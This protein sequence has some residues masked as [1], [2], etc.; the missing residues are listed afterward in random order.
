M[1]Q[2]VLID[3]PLTPD[4]ILL[5][6]RGAQL[7]LSDQA[8]E[9]IKT[10]R[11]IV[12][13][14]VESGARGYGI[15]T[16]VGALCDIVISEENQ[17]ALSHN[18]L[19][20]HACG[21]GEPLEVEA[22]RA[23]MATQINNYAL[24]KSG[25]SWDCV[26]V[27]LLLLN[28]GITPVV[29][30]RGSVGYLTQTASI[31]LILL[32]AGQARQNGEVISGA[33]ALA[34][35]ERQP[36]VL[37]AKEGLSLV[38]GTPCATGLAILAHARIRELAD[39][40]DAA[41]ALSYS[42]LA[43]QSE[44]FTGSTIML[45]RSA[46]VQVTTENLLGW[47]EGVARAPEAKR[48]TQDPLSL[49]AIPQVHGAIRDELHQIHDVLATELCGV[50]DN[51]TVGG[52]PSEPKVFSQANAVGAAVAFAADR[53]SIVAA[54]L[55]AISERRVD[56]LVN[57]LVSDLPAFLTTEAGTGSGF[58]IA[59]YTA[60]SLVNENRML[61]TPASLGNGITSG[62][63]E[64]ILTHATPAAEKALRV[65]RNVGL[66]LSIELLCGAQAQDLIT[67]DLKRGSRLQHLYRTLRAAVPIY[68]DDR[69]L[70]IDIERMFDEI[71][72][73][74]PPYEIG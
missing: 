69:P 50:S 39:W 38:N 30:S 10:A 2:T 58:M 44:T 22:V 68:K 63:Q 14:F 62:L 15:N 25:L 36:R 19:Y 45:R 6:A 7:A 27:L 49:R 41:A 74:R 57:P 53:I 32:G 59:Q 47:L 64:D 29:P 61:G 4:Q 40:A 34:R 37:Q 9:R 11:Y 31:G 1:T 65:V 54:Q 48:S 18:I 70:N 52:T 21:M 66:I 73:Q 60:T 46:G 12:E 67:E 13:A 17:S 33:E 72:G 28:A 56:R 55:G 43:R 8:V 51:P 35:I 3:D 26:D 23:I 71:S 20:S 24:G 42:V 16:G 5:V